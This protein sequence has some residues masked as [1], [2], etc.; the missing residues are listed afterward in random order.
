MADKARRD[1]VDATMREA[2]TFAQGHRAGR[3]EGALERAE[4]E[5]LCRQQI[6]AYAALVRDLVELQ[7]ELQ[8]EFAELRSL[9]QALKALG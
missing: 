5:K 2:L 8:A 6:E 3:R 4:W 1:E 7:A 9:V